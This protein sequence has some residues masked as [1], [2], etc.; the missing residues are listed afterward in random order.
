MSFDHD[1]VRYL[2]MYGHLIDNHGVTICFFQRVVVYPHY[3][4]S[5]KTVAEG[6]R[7]PKELGKIPIWQNKKLN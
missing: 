2:D 4:W 7:I 6:R 1:K 3:I 5:G